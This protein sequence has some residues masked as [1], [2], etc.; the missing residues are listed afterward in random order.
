MSVTYNLTKVENNNNISEKQLTFLI[1]LYVKNPNN[2]I[3][4]EDP[5]IIVEYID[6]FQASKIIKTLLSYEIVVITFND[7]PTENKQIFSQVDYFKTLSIEDAISNFENTI[8]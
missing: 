1:D 2:Y 5:K 4:S 3:D 7:E 6:K 8:D